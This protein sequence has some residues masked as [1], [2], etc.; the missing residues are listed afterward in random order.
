MPCVFARRTASCAALAVSIWPIPSCPSIKARPP[1]S[2]TSSGFAFGS[3]TPAFRRAAYQESRITPWDWWPHKSAWTSVSAQRRA[4]GFAQTGRDVD[5]C[6]EYQE[7]IGINSGGSD[8]RNSPI[9]RLSSALTN[10]KQVGLLVSTIRPA[11]ESLIPVLQ[12]N[13]VPADNNDQACA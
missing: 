1:A 10:V 5:G 3:H 9:L 6:R 11:G 13:Y 4:V 7:P 2:T 12:S 8:H